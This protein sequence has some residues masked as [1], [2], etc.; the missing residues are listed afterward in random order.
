MLG[1][2]EPPHFLK[3]QTHLTYISEDWWDFF[4]KFRN[5]WNVFNVILKKL[6]W[7]A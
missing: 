1:H 2:G 3:I 5:P 4:K 6:Q 7:E